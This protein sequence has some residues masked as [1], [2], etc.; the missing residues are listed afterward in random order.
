MWSTLLLAGALAAGTPIERLTLG[1][2][3]RL[4]AEREPT[5]LA[6]E[7]EMAAASADADFAARLPAPMWMVGVENLPITGMDAGSFGAEDMTMRMVGVEQMWPSARMREAGRDAAL[8]MGDVARIQAEAA[9]RMRAREAGRMW[10]EGW[11]A[12]A[13]ARVLREEI[14]ALDEA[15]A[16]ATGMARSEPGGSEEALMLSVERAET[17]AMA[18]VMDGERAGVE[19][20]FAAELG[21]PVALDETRPDWTLPELASLDAVIDRHP[22]LRM[23]AAMRLQA[24]SESGMA[25]AQGGPEWRLSARY[26]ARSDGRD[27]ML[28][29]EVGVRFDAFA[30]DRQDA[31]E[32]AARSRAEAAEVRLAAKRREL[33]QLARSARAKAAAAQAA[34]QRIA[35]AL[36]PAAADHAA[37]VRS[38][39]ASGDAT[40]ADA[41]TAER[42]HYV[43]HREALRLEGEALLALVDLYS[44]L[45]EWPQ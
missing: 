19:D 9:R 4:S 31:R 11:R 34:H 30:S 24:E 26:G 43:H 6:A 16:A 20:W 41:L 3:V 21:A 5:A 8:A 2:A 40:L 1:T 29:L 35:H 45:P 33:T 36:L 23:A 27:D 22:E 12:A 7:H 10:V 37:L 32:R 28:G 14:A 13:T 44:L 15:I 18:E 17:E 25:Q 42:M 39:Y 38:R